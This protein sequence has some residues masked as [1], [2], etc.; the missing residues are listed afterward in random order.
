MENK[1]KILAVVTTYNR[2][3]LAG[4]LLSSLNEVESPSFDV[5]LVDD[6]ST[7]NYQPLLNKK[8]NFPLSYIKNEKNQG[9]ASS[10]NQGLD[11]ALAKNY[12]YVWLLDDDVMVE[13]DT[14]KHL[15]DDLAKDKNIAA[16]GSALY[17]INNKNKLISLGYFFNFQTLMPEKNYSAEDVDYIS[18]CSDLVDLGVIKKTGLR[19][20]EKYFL[21][22]YDIDFYLQLKRAGY[23]II[24]SHNSKAYHPDFEKDSAEKHYYNLRNNTYFA[25]KFDP[26]KF[27]NQIIFTWLSW[28]K[29]WYRHG[30]IFE[31]LPIYL[32]LHD[33]TNLKMG[34]RDFYK[35]LY[36]NRL[37]ITQGKKILF[38]YFGQNEELKKISNLLANQNCQLTII[39]KDQ[40]IE[41]VI[42][43][44]RNII[45][46]DKLFSKIKI[47]LKLFNGF[48][49]IILPGGIKNLIYPFLA[50]KKIKLEK[51]TNQLYY[52]KSNFLDY[53]VFSLKI[54]CL[55]LKIIFRQ[56]FG[57][58]NWQQSLLIKNIKS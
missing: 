54:N 47:Y 12:D 19:F 3:E 48:D 27:K 20:D 52:L 46:P 4:D 44:Q 26:K 35:A 11:Y 42:P 21:R 1:I 41:K 32:A 34:Q 18:T 30:Y 55:F 51:N 2:V 49:Y 43:D 25:L 13:K 17:D 56:N 57:L 29:K 16:S 7:A 9:P 28:A 53:T 36:L 22:S 5:L 24:A 40:R 37:E 10:L 39:T 33:L 14:L 8:Y 6:N 23:R 31:A 58:K 45:L 50:R 15:I 38:P